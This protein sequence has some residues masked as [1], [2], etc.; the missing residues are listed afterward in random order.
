[1]I[2]CIYLGIIC[3]TF[4]TNFTFLSL[5]KDFVLANSADPDE[6]PH[7]VV[8]TYDFT[9][10][11]STLFVVSGLQRI[12]RCPILLKVRWIKDIVRSSLCNTFV[13]G[14]IFQILLLKEG[15]TAGRQFKFYF[16]PYYQ[17]MIS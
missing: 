9:V 17:K 12:N 3:Y 5:K 16:K 10:C 2:H 14:D 7:Y 1:M 8:F 4:Q 13:S 6:M 15:L 11:Q